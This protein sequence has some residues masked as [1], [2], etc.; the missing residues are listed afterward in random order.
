MSAISDYYQFNLD[1][2]GASVRGRRITESDRFFVIQNPT[3]SFEALNGIN[4]SGNTIH[5]SKDAVV[6][7]FKIENDQM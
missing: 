4:P 2:K 7:Y 5:L 3:F 1:F 6:C